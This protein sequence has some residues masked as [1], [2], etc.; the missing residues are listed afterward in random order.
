MGR[1]TWG[2]RALACAVVLVLGACSDPGEPPTEA[3]FIAQGL[4]TNSLVRTAPDKVEWTEH[5]RCLYAATSDDIEFQV[6]FMAVEP[7]GELSGP[8]AQ[9]FNRE[10]ARCVTGA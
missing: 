1:S 7:G 8:Q 2:H 3:A 5:Y 9:T 10:I 6:A 4:V